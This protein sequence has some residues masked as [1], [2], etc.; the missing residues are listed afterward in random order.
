MQPLNTKNG[1]HHWQVTS[2]YWHMA[3]DDCQMT[4]YNLIDMW[5]DLMWLESYNKPFGKWFS[6]D[7]TVESWMR[8]GWNLIL[9]TLWSLAVIS[10]LSTWR[11]EG[12]IICWCLVWGW[13]RREVDNLLMCGL[14]M[15]ENK[16]SVDNLLMCGLRMNEK[17]S[18]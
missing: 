3:L 17:R 11:I 13:M 6:I 9:R 15:R 10:C 5:H 14:R 18:G 8:I 7:E 4:P 12:W 1:L 16:R 2:F